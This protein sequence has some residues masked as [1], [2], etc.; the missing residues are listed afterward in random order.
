[1][2]TIKAT[3]IVLLATGFLLLTA[4]D[5]EEMFDTTDTIP[6][7]PVAS[8]VYHTAWINEQHDT[9]ED[10]FG[11]PQESVETNI[12]RFETDTTGHMTYMYVTASQNDNESYPFSY[13]YSTPNGTIT[14]SEGG[15]TETFR[16]A[17]NASNNTLALYGSDGY[18]LIF[19]R[20]EE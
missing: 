12:I 19:S 10:E 6:T 3:A 16:F 1:M 2:K 18:Y 4:C 13:T 17:Y 7:T 5:P 15:E 20:L 11:N 9:Y 8:D 14:I